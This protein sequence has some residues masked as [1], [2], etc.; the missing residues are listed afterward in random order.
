MSRREHPTAVAGL[1]LA[2]GSSTRYPRGAKLLLPFRD[3]TVVGVSALAARSAGLAPL[4]VVVGHRAEQVR[5]ALGGMGVRFVENPDYGQGIGTSLAAGVRVI[6]DEESVGAVVILLG[7]EP[8]V[9]P[10]VIRSVAAAWRAHGTAA[11]RAVYRDRPGHPVLVDRQ[12][13]S[14]LEAASG[15]RGV[16][17]LLGAAGLS[18]EE[19]AID[20]LAP[21]DID[22]PADYRAA[23]ARG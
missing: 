1:I 7:D 8:G 16:A 22:T 13:F 23:S 5:E 11:A 2:A 15:P 3:G 21:V 14:A 10:D 20:A 6:A 17:K 4:V 12:L 9:S 19:V 18:F